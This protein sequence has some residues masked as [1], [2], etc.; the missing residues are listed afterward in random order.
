MLE[1]LVYG[2]EVKQTESL[3]VSNVR[4]KD[5]LVRALS[6]IRDGRLQAE[7]GAALDFI[8]I[9]VKSAWE[10]L[11]E[12]IGETVTDTIIEEV[13]ARFCLGK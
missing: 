8:E 11:G 6:F 3:L 1:D 12:I 10:L 7:E 2:G 4:Q 13:F 5:L 9:D